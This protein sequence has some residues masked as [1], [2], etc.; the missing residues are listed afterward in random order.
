MKRLFAG[1]A[2][3]RLQSMPAERPSPE[4]QEAKVAFFEAVVSRS[5]RDAQAAYR[6]ISR[7]VR[8]E[9]RVSATERAKRNQRTSALVKWICALREQREADARG[10]VRHPLEPE[11]LIEANAV[12]VRFCR[13]L[14]GDDSVGTF[15]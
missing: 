11:Q 7:Y 10:V 9:P 8:P 2:R 4:L 1:L 12:M 6:V 13:W 14:A 3:R 15:E 5:Y